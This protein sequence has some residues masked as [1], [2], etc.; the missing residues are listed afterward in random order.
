MSQANKSASWPALILA[1]LML[2][3][4]AQ[5]QQTSEVTTTP[6][7]PVAQ[8]LTL[9]TGGAPSE[10]QALDV[11]LVSWDPNIPADVTTHRAEG[12]FPGVR[13]AEGLYLPFLLRRTL[14]ESGQ[15][16]AVRV[17]PEPTTGV[18][19][20]VEGTL[21][22]STGSELAVHIRAY[23]STGR[24]WLDKIYRDYSA[25]ED[26][27]TG[28]NGM[29]EPFED[30][31]VQLAND[32]LAV[33]RTLSEPELSA[34]R[35]VSLLRYAGE[36]SPDAFGNYLAQDEGGQWQLQ[37]LPARGDP[38][39]QR[40]QKIRDHE[41]L[42]IDTVDEQYARLFEDMDPTYDLWR[43]FS[44]ELTVYQQAYRERA[45]NRKD[46]AQRGSYEALKQTYNDYKWS[47]IQEQDAR[48]LARGFNNEVQ[49]TVLEVEGRVVNLSGSLDKQYEEWQSILR[50]I[51]E[52]E[53][54]V[55]IAPVP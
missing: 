41:Y 51:F 23:D 8:A 38:M 39:M 15:W 48:E 27:S 50:R 32:L 42:F 33:R 47:R 22:T 53:T 14:E 45:A 16:G 3:G 18:D 55:P 30:L 31:Y 21:L 29:G 17:F 19:L 7:A 54:G 1:A 49:P 28:A 25:E 44:R 4:C 6:L 40:V 26:F 5:S 24:Q 13:E 46:R 20:S 43:Q 12:I 9:Q 36:L 11:A 2:A 37:R 52:L 34:V 10:A 35:E